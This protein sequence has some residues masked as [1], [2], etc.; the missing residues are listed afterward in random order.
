MIVATLGSIC[1]AARSA[2]PTSDCCQIPAAAL[3][4]AAPPSLLRM[5]A[6]EYFAHA[7]LTSMLSL[8]PGHHVAMMPSPALYRSYVLQY[9]ACKPHQ[10]PA[11]CHQPLL[12]TLSASL[13]SSCNRV[14]TSTSA[15]ARCGQDAKSHCDSALQA[16]LQH[17]SRKPASLACRIGSTSQLQ[18]LLLPIL[19]GMVNH[20]R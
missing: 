14:H 15:F 11:V 9:A 13:R 18:I 8:C 20:E 4:V 16:R 10:L 3:P 1:I 19:A 17:I 5:I 12:G 6:D 2:C 7:S